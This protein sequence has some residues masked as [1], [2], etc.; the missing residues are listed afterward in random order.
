MIR[1]AARVPRGTDAATIE[2]T[3]IANG[4]VAA[5]GDLDRVA[6][7]AEGLRA[8]GTVRAYPMRSAW[9][10]LAFTGALGAE[11]ALRRRAGQR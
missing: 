3:M 6:S 7:W 11:W 1:P 8:S 4:G 2:R 10:L 5:R 9:W